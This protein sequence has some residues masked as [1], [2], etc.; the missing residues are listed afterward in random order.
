MLFIGEG[1]RGGGAPPSPAPAGDPRSVAPKGRLAPV[2]QT[3]S[4]TDAWKPVPRKSP[5]PY[6][7]EPASR[8]VNKGKTEDIP[9]VPTKSQSRT[10][11]RQRLLDLLPESPLEP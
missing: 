1:L 11:P 3:N 2:R 4:S 9:R 8:G 6:S 10:Q 7:E 5:Y